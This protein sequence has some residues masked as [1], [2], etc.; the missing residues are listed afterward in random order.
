MYWEEIF[1]GLSERVG[2]IQWRIWETKEKK[3]EATLHSKQAK[4]CARQKSKVLV[5]HMAQL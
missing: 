5:Y 2:I 1:L 4:N 3:N